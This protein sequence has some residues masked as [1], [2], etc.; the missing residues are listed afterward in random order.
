MIVRPTSKQLLE[1]V[2]KE[3][4]NTVTPAVSNPE[5]LAR[6]GMIDSILG[7][8]AARSNH[9]AAWIREEITEIERGAQEVLAA[10][11]DQGGHVAAALDALRTKRSSSNRLPDLHDEYNLAGEVLSCALE[12]GLLAG[13]ELRKTMEGILSARLARE[14]EIRGDFNLAGR[15]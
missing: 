4:R 14:V 12:A 5:V 10:K 3:L 8:V 7:S 6:L 9:E 2:R 15:E 11:A 1:A 13:G